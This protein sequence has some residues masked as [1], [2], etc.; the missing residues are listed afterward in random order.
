MILT[1]AEFL[2]AF[3][4]DENEPIHI[5]SFKTKEVPESM[6]IKPKMFET[7]VSKLT[8]SGDI[9]IDLERK[10]KTSGIYF[11]VNSGGNEDKYITRY[12]A[13]FV[14]NDNLPIEHQQEA[15]DNCPIQPSI[16]VETRKSIHAY[17]LIDGG[18]SE[19]DW[20]EVQARLISYF[21]GDQKIKNPSRCMRLPFFNHVTY[22]GTKFEYKEVE[23]VAFAP[24]QKFTVEQ[25]KE[26]FPSAISQS[27]NVTS[28]DDVTTDNTNQVYETWESLNGELGKR[29]AQQGKLNSRGKYEMRCPN[30]N[31]KTETSLFYDPN[32]ESMKCLGGCSHSDILQAFGLPKSPTKEQETEYKDAR[33]TP[34]TLLVALAEEIELFTSE[35]DDSY[36]TI[37][38]NGH[39]ETWAIESKTFQNWLGK[40]YYQIHNQAPS[41]YALEEAIG[42]LDGE[43]KFGFESEKKQVFTR[44]A[45]LNGAIYLDLANESWE[46]VRVNPD[47]WEVVSDYPVKFRRTKG[48]KPIPAPQKG[49]SL[50]ELDK[51]LNIHD[52]DLVLVKA[53]LI[54]CLKPKI[55]YPILIL[56]GE[57]GSA[58][59]TAAQ[60]LC[61]LIDPNEASLRSEPRNEQDLA[62]AATNRLVVAFDNLSGVKHWLSD[63][64]C[65]ISTG[66]GF[67]TKKLYTDAE[68]KIFNLQNPILLNGID[69]LATRSDLL[70]R[71]IIVHLP[72]IE[73]RKPQS[74][75]WNDF[76]TAKPRIFGAV[77]DAVSEGLRNFNNVHLED[78]PRMAD[79]T[80]FAT[81]AENSLGLNKNE[82]ASIYNE[83]RSNSNSL[84]IETSLIAPAITTLLSINAQWIGSA[85]ELKEQIDRITPEVVQRSPYYPR[86]AQKV[87]NDLRRIAPNLREQGIDVNIGKDR[88]GGTGKE[89]VRFFV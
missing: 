46:A 15:L 54:A 73:S 84:A 8:N 50:N 55:G 88:E 66:G 5:R 34:A 44:I 19:S 58:K 78:Y 85:Q 59:S 80:K 11:V 21:D 14:E 74:D 9:Q 45:E 67:A 22:D 43:A 57:Q 41:K 72:K 26:A 42:M 83:N 7:T 75:F 71:S 40:R 52:D 1:S 37:P 38:V 32:R 23:V 48:M 76:I 70:D 25:M 61:E 16:R 13:F 77:L 87:A 56:H 3:F 20:R 53:W 64:L 4:P 18:C 49:G 51:F 31:G 27:E 36:A 10:N 79:F 30:H 12:N 86:I 6:G 63:A 89:G 29:I 81:A 82:F 62:I 33:Q 28:C 68:E 69:D 35:S 24:S 60:V 39:E 2:K 65:R 17:W 47:G